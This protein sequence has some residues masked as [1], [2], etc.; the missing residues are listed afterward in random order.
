MALSPEDRRKIIHHRT[1]NVIGVL[2]ETQSAIDDQA[3]S[4]ASAS[5]PATAADIASMQ[6]MLSAHKAALQTWYTTWRNGDPV[7]PA[8]P[9]YLG[10][11]GTPS[12]YVNNLENAGSIP[13]L[14]RNNYAAMSL[15][16]M[17]LED[18]YSVAV[19]L[20][21]GAS[22]L[23]EVAMDA[24]EAAIPIVESL[25]E[26]VCTAT[27]RDLNRQDSTIPM[28]AATTAVQDTQAA[29]NGTT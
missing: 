6:S 27:V 12:A 23:K 18:L 28:S 14:T 29:W 22:G 9:A 8:Q 19:A 16:A 13:T 11:F 5:W 2:S 10:V 26:T 1:A 3:T 4:V 15:V 25:S 24:L 17:A 20:E 7:E 21:T